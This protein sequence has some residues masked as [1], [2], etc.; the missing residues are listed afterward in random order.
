MKDV[1]ETMELINASMDE[2]S[3][4][5]ISSHLTALKIN[6]PN[7]IGKICFALNAVL[8]VMQDVEDAA[9]KMKLKDIV[10]VAFSQE[11]QQQITEAKNELADYMKNSKDAENN[12]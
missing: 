5:N 2:L 12:D 11:E 4:D 10:T 8:K 9:R 1:F 6:L 7:L 3:I